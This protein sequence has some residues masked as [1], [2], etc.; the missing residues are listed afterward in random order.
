MT[1]ECMLAIGA[2]VLTLA[3]AGGKVPLWAPVLI[4][5]LLEVLR[6]VPMR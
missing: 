4:L 3:A 6:C 1:A 2:L 5:A